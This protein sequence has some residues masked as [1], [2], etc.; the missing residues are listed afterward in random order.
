MEIKEKDQWQFATS[1]MRVILPQVKRTN[2]ESTIILFST[3]RLLE[4]IGQFI[5]PKGK[6]ALKS[7]P[8]IHE[9]D[10]KVMSSNHS[11]FVLSGP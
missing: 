8:M 2:E 1:G 3:K 4:V 11:V 10:C 7:P 5:S 9:S 6:C